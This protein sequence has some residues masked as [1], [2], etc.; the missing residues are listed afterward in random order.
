[1]TTDSIELV[2]LE[3]ALSAIADAIVWAGEDGK[4]TWC[5][6]A[7]D[8][9]VDQPHAMTINAKL[10][11]LLP[12][13]QKGQ[14]IE[15]QAYPTAK[16]LSGETVLSAY[17]FQQANRCLTLEISG[18]RVTLG[19]QETA[20]LVIRDV[21]SLRPSAAKSQTT[22]DALRRS[23]AEY[24]AFVTATAQ[25]VWM[26]NAAGEVVDDIPL[27]CALT[28]RSQDSAKGWG[29]LESVHPDDRASTAQVWLDAVKSGK[30]YED[31]QRVRVA[32]GEYR[33]FAVRGVPLLDDQGNI[34]KWIGTQTDITE[35]KQAEETLR[36]QNALLQAQQQ[37][38]QEK[39]AQYKTI[40]EA[41]TDGLYITDLE[42]TN[43]VEVNPAA[44]RMHGYEYEEFLALHPSTY[45]HPSTLPVFQEYIETVRAGQQFYGQAIDIHKDGSLINVEI[46]GTTC[47]Y[48]GKP[49][50]LAIVRD[51]SDRKSAEE[52][53]RRSELKYRNLFENAQVGIYRISLENGLILEANPYAIAAIGYDSIDEVVGKKYT[54][55]FYADLAERALVL[56]EV[57]QH[58]KV[59]NYEMQ[60]CH[61]DGSIRWGMFT[62]SLNLAENLLE[63]VFVDITPRKQ[64]EEAL[65]R[66][67]L[68]YRHLFEN[69]QVGIGRTRIEDGLFLDA[70]QRC[71]D[72]LHLSS[73]SDLIGKR[74][75]SE[76]QANPQARQ[77]MLNEL[78]QNGEVRDLET[79][80][81]RADGSTGWG[82]FSLRPS[83]EEDC[84]EFVMVDISDRKAAEEA[85]QRRAELDNLLSQ[86]SRQFIDQDAETAI[87]AVLALIT[88]HIGAERGCLFEYHNDQAECQLLYEWCGEN[89]SP[90]T[91]E[92][93]GSSVPEYPLLH[94]QFLAGEVLYT[95][96]IQTIPDGPER[97]LFTRQSIQSLLG[98]P[99]IYQG[100]VTGFIGLDVV[101]FQKTWSQEDVK[102][103]KLVGELIAIGRARHKAEADLRI[104]KEAAE[105]AN[106]AKST[107]LANMSH[108]LR[109][110]LNAI[111][112]FAQLMER[113][114]ALSDR[115]R[116]SLAIINRSGEHLLSLINDVLE[117]SKIEAGRTTLNLVAFDL[118][119]LL[120]TL[121][122]MFL[123]RTKAK[124]LSLDF[125]IAS[126]LPQY[127]TADESKLR[128]VFINLLT[129]AVKFTDTG[130][131]KLC[132]N[133][134]DPLTLTL[135]FEV[136]DSGCG[137]APN[138]IDGLFRPFIQTSSGLQIREGTG[139][140]LTISRR[141]VQ[142]MGGDIQVKTAL[143]KGSTFSFDLP[144]AI[145]EVKEVVPSSPLRRVLQLA[146]NQL[147]YRILVVDDRAEN[148]SLV[149][150]LL[151][152]VGFETRSAIHGKDAI[153][154]WQQWK[155]HLIL[156]DMRM[157]VID[158]YEATRQ[159]RALEATDH[160][161]K[162]IALTA[163]AFEEQRASILA[164]GCDDFVAK[165]FRESLLFDKL[166]EHLGVTYICD[167]ERETSSFSSSFGLARLSLQN[168]PI[169]WI[170]ELHQ[171]ALAVDAERIAQLIKQIPDCGSFE[172][173][174]SANQELAD[175]LTELT[176]QFCFDE[177][178]EL[179]EC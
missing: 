176:Q 47:S 86:I 62:L 82:L 36:R 69:S 61:R 90:L 96:D 116:N 103:L 149:E 84:L 50:V 124:R 40:F 79:E 92:A 110:P 134:I 113:D 30:I 156:M 100:D 125:E 155:P 1:M 108:E 11:D 22:E 67:E 144:V 2:N 178:L 80:L 97:Q 17:E 141:F 142:L 5:N 63:A 131:I 27:W 78:R 172:V 167:E 121:H 68:K 77:L 174:Q 119:Y 109:T 111:L 43:P 41:I 166:A 49:H 32:S 164:A 72:I 95:T 60:F 87:Q 118:H 56:T 150:Q 163:S 71:A 39:E 101:H 112:G 8:R 114:V 153:A 159:I 37:T 10:S 88:R 136:H 75:T 73:P 81:H 54:T 171:A 16:A 132:A 64:T 145:A 154:W 102:S 133:S 70:N 127:I 122:E 147:S 148:R 130:S 23:E 55:D 83:L 26:T 179:T 48:N 157:P 18:N 161:T 93:R 85:L 59:T 4:V 126:D 65:R 89:I 173:A 51:I 115:Q 91:P 44:C 169:E 175:V 94:Q 104:A 158:G 146:P 117:M 12:L 76:F 98:V 38:L 9:L 52:A 160:H 20:V 14:P 74:F 135:R 143:G 33:L 25:A 24:R 31:E 152:A 106:I 57:H 177:I 151:T 170:T 46:K 138:E 99:I 123:I 66:S 28:G 34:Q 128:Q 6:A 107:F 45:I 165:P 7:F 3:A 139:L 168:M 15:P 29:W 53:L 162:I 42:T 137:I 120:Q 105:A 13:L 58:G 35:Q 140:G 21:T 129:N 19:N